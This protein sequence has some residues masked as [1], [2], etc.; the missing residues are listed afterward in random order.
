MTLNLMEALRRDGHELLAITSTSTDGEFSRRLERI[1]VPQAALP[2]GTFSKKLSLLALHW[3]ADT[4]IK[5]P[6]VWSGWTRLRRRFRPDLLILTNPKQ[7]MFLYPW[8]RRQP[9]LLLEHSDKAVN[10]GNRALYAALNRQ[11]RFFVATS[12]FMA[13]HLSDLGIS[14]EKIRIIKIGSF[15]RERREQF[16]RPA[17]NPSAV[18]NAP[19]RIGIAGQISP[20][21]GYDYLLE[22]AAI[23]Q[24]R[25]KNFVIR[26]FGSGNEDYLQDL[27]ARVVAVGLEKKWDWRGYETDR[28]RI[29][30]EFD[31]LVVPSCFPEPFGMVAVEASAY[32]LPV[33]ATRCGGLPEIVRD[34]ETGWLVEP[35]NSEQLADRICWFIDHP[36]ERRHFGNAARTRAFEVFALETTLA[37]FKE[38][39]DS[40]LAPTERNVSAAPRSAAK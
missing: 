13:Q 21:K 23:L 8:L 28:D 32:G 39:F 6:R 29:Y 38:L 4:L 40:L 24:E 20:H 9:S 2:L 3:T 11:L 19:L 18:N 14:P 5:L 36:E 27:K 22:A 25:R 33:I 37:E 15:F 30:R 31:V 34:G 7:G 16:S 26:A 10:S 17:P 1:G 35:R 12:D